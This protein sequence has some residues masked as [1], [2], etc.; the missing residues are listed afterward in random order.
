MTKAELVKAIFKS[1]ATAT[2]QEA[3]KALGAVID[4]L[5]GSLVAGDVITL[6]NFRWL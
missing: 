3:G 6:P 5:K 2:K 1:G 4:I